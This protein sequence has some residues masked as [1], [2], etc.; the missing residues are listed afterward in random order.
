MDRLHTFKLAKD[1]T[2]SSRVSQKGIM[3]SNDYGSIILKVIRDN[4][5]NKNQ[6]SYICKSKWVI[7]WTSYKIRMTVFNF[8][9]VNTERD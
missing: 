7:L 6:E 9:H 2:G 8:K 3:L 4:I 1:D 5:Q